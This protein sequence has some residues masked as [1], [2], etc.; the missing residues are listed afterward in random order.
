MLAGCGG[1][2]GGGN[3]GGASNLTATTPDPSPAPAVVPQGGKAALEIKVVGLPVD[4]P[5]AITI[6]GADG[7]TR[8]LTGP[9]NLNDVPPGA[10]AVRAELIVDGVLRYSPSISGAPG[11]LV[12]GGSSSVTVSYAF[13][14]VID[15]TLYG[16][17]WHL[18]NTGQPAPNGVPGLAGADI[19]VEPIWKTRALGAGSVVA[20][21]DNG[22][23]LAH[24]DLAANVLPGRSYN[25]TNLSTDPTGSATDSAHGTSV[26][27]IIAAR[28]NGRGVLGVAPRAGLLGFNA[29]ATGLDS[30]IAD[31]M[32]RDLG[33]SVSNNSWG[34]QGAASNL[35]GSQ[36]SPAPQV[37]RSAIETG[38]AQGRSGKG[39]VYVFSAGNSGN[40]SFTGAP[41]FSE[42]SNLDGHANHRGVVAVGALN[43]RGEAAFFTEPGANVWVSAPGGAPCDAHG[44]TTTDRSA[45]LGFNAGGS[46][47]DYGNGNYSKCFAGTSAAV[48]TVAG[49]VAL[50]LEA[51][52][53][54]SWRDVRQVLARSAR[55]TDPGNAD[56]ATNAAG[57]NIHPLFGFGAVDA[58]AAVGL[59]KSW[60][61]VGPTLTAVSAIDNPNLGI[62]DNDATGVSRA[63][64]VAPAGIGK[65]EWIEISFSAGHT[66]WGDLEVDLTSP[67]GTVSRLTSVHRRIVGASYNNHVFGSARHLDESAAGTWTL[68]VRDRV[69]GFTGTLQSWSLKV[70]GRAS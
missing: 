49:V 68:T 37:W 70:Y 52:P 24:E 43:D 7:Y 46:S 19:N 29:L 6:F 16:D 62:P 35:R 51:N 55:K 36:I 59:A 22:L 64:T 57:R 14:L 17:Q 3:A 44:I 65:I 42:N 20:V 9:L 28:D 2:G 48:P 69:A 45:A 47:I 8:N 30:D 39:I 63:L 5:A 21:V 12:A 38:L 23:E 33:I 26:A 27:G 1:G 60:T 50:M 4:M 54:L 56:W 53:N 32:S 66:F 10:Y 18:K 13:A 31:A 25:Y 41:T 61:N 58:Q 34:A 11:T 15:D 40:I 67:S